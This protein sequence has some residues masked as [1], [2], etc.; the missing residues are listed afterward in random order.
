[1]SSSSLDSAVY[2]LFTTHALHLADK[3]GVL[4]HLI[5][6]GPSDPAA[7]AAARGIDQ[8]TLERL[9]IVLAA[10]GLIRRAADGAYAP[11]AELVPFLDPAD[12]RYLGG[13]VRHLVENTAGQLGRLDAYL[14]RGKAA[15]DAGLPS[16]F[17]SI[18]RDEQATADFLEAM[19]NLSFEPSRELAALAGLE[20]TGHLVD[21]G[22]ASGAFAVAALTRYPELR[23]TVF[24]LP[25]VAPHLARTRDAH[26]LDGRLEFAP[27]DFFTDELPAADC[28][29][30]GYI[31]SD[32]EDEFCVEL[33]RKAYR[34]LPPG[35]RVL[36]MERLFDEDGGPLPTAA[37]NLSMHVETRGRHRTAAEYAGLLT[38][39]GFT[40][41]ATH[42]STWDKHLVTGRRS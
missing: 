12:P 20:G 4:A 41:A 29:S 18:Y 2:G 3:H 27:G 32:W 8:E 15:V 23:V 33:L 21:V 37:M 22:G 35:G 9:L 26:G 39:A 31:L 10:A 19:W 24:D 36:V 25:Q 30:F 11:V 13:F 34:A 17:E 6:H 5:A 40:G 16:P 42:R 1:M 28:V 38:A 14:V 7:I